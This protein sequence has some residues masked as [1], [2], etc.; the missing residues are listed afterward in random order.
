MT[1]DLMEIK[2]TQ[3]TID[4]LK[5]EIMRLN[6]TMTCFIRI[7]SVAAYEEVINYDKTQAKDS[8]P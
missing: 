2:T 8:Q 6:H 4:A 7:Y 1:N 3:E 5:K